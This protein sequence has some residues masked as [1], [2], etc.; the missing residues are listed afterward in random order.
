MPYSPA[1]LFDI[2]WYSFPYV[3]LTK[4]ERMCLHFFFLSFALFI[5]Y[6][7]VF[8]IPSNTMFLLSRGYYYLSGTDTVQNISVQ[9]L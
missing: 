7:I 8:Y 9:S 2:Y 4:P 6:G 3:M 5:G 1:K